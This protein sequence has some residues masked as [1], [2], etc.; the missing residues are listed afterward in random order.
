MRRRPCLFPL[1]TPALRLMVAYYLLR[2]YYI[3]RDHKDGGGCPSYF[4]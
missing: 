3:L 1:A 2:R 4:S